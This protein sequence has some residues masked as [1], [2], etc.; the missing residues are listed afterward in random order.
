MVSLLKH[1]FLFIFQAPV[2]CLL[3]VNTF[4]ILPLGLLET[5]KKSISS[6]C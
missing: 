6:P 2:S 4:L 1:L 3:F 5:L